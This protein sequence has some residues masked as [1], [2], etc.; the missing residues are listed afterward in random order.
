MADNDSSP[1]F[2]TTR[3]VAALLRVR[4]RK[5]YEMA[6]AEE[7]PCRRV[8]GKLLFP[9]TA[10]ETWLAGPSD[11]PAAPVQAAAR[12]NVIAGSHDPLLDWALR[13]AETGLATFFDGSLDGLKRLAAG[14]AMA[15]GL[16]VFEPHHDDWNVDHASASEAGR[17]CVLLEWAKRRQGFI[18]GAG[19]K[20]N[21]RQIEDLRGHRIALRQKSAGSRILFDHLLGRS[22]LS[23]EDLTIVAATARTETDA[24]TLVAS[25]QA[26]VS[27][28]LEA[29]ARQFNLAFVPLVEERY[30]LLIDRRSFFEP[31][32][33]NLFAFCRSPEFTGKAEA[34]GGYDLSSHGHVHWNSP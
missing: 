30:D 27:L 7:I 1:E 22:G 9:R 34:M 33:Q 18:L 4:E 13:E 29:G 14:E 32:L 3:E 26:D 2:L 10:I 23:H 12:P 16:H 24:A 31:P 25:G 20:D 19:L 15:C 8:T 28:G 17:S 21:I 5:V 6:A 11:A